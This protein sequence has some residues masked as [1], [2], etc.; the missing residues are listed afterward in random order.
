MAADSP[1]HGG[2]LPPEPTGPEPDLGRRPEPAAAPPPAPASGY[3]PPAH[4]QP[5]W[6]PPAQPQGWQHPQAAAPDNGPAVLGFSLSISSLGLLIISAGLSTLLSVGLAIP[7]M[8]QSRKGTQ[9][10]REGVTDRNAGLANAGW[11]LGIVA[12]VLSALATIFWI[13]IAIVVATDDEARRE[14]EREFDR[15]YDQSSMSALIVVARLVGAA[16]L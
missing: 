12:L 13:V 6:Q 16:L 1:G 7:G 15:Q 4:A 8:V 14:F 11:I 3:E 9:R 10:V 2:F 5:G